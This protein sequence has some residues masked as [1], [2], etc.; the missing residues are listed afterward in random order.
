M[1]RFR[2]GHPDHR[3]QGGFMYVF[4]DA[5]VLHYCDNVS[6]RAICLLFLCT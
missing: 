4:S 2:S 5:Y 6:P 1:G 3:Q